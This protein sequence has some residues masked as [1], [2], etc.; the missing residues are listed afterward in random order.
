MNY[1][2]RSSIHC[3]L[4]RNPKHRNN[5]S[6]RYQLAKIPLKDYPNYQ[7]DSSIRF[8]FVR[9]PKCSDHNLPEAVV[10]E[11]VGNTVVVL[12]EVADSMAVAVAV[13]GMVVVADD[14]EV[15]VD[16]AAQ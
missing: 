14:M 8:H 3:R 5:R 2:L 9:N 12:V 10:A 7:L 13:G 1:L 11:V 16:H 15:V 6:S 4:E